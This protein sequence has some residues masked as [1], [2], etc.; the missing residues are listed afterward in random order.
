M[1]EDY[2]NGFAVEKKNK[3]YSKLA[4]NLYDQL[5][6]QATGLTQLS[7]KIT[8]CYSSKRTKLGVA[9][10]AVGAALLA[11][12]TVI[13]LM[14]FGVLSIPG[15]GIGSLGASFIIAGSGAAGFG[16]FGGGLGLT[17]TGREKSAAKSLTNFIKVTDD[18]IQKRLPNE[19]DARM[20]AFVRKI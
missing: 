14:T 15:I 11:L 4:Q 2:S 18:K 9:M 5:F 17:V 19:A 8:G 13:T 3:D 10:M 7:Q 16:L 12:A 20:R 1:I 6:Q